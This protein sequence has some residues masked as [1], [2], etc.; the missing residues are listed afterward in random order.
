MCRKGRQKL[1]DFLSFIKANT[2][3]CII[4]AVLLVG[5]AVVGVLLVG[6]FTDQPPVNPEQTETAEGTAPETDAVTGAPVTETETETEAPLPYFDAESDTA[7]YPSKH[8]TDCFATVHSYSEAYRIYAAYPNTDS[9]Q[10][11]DYCRTTAESLITASESPETAREGGTTIVTVDYKLYLAK[12]VYSAVF[13]RKQTETPV[14]KITTS[15]VVLTYN[16]ETNT[17]Y[18]PL[19][20]YDMTLASEP[21][22]QKIRAGYE[23]AFAERGL[24]AD[25]EFLDEVCTPDPSS[26]VNIAVDAHS[27]YFFTVYDKRIIPELLCAEVPFDGMVEYTWAA[28]E[29]EKQASQLP[30]Q[31]PEEQPEYVELPSYD[32][33]AAV[34]A[35]E[36]VGDDYFDDAL[37]IGNSLIVGL[38]RTVPLNARYFASVG[39]NVS[40]VFT[41]ELIPMQSGDTYTISEALGTVEFSKVYLMFGINELGWGSIASFINY[42]GQIID[43]I[44]EVNPEAI[45]Y[46]QSILPINEEK[47]AKSRDYQS[48]I[49]NF[50]VATFN[51]KIIDM[52]VQKNVAFVNVGE[53]LTDETGNLYSD[54]TSDGIHIGG[55]F[56]TRWVEYL[57]THTVQLQI[58]E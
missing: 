13:T 24:S 53:V 5:V 47:W 38:Q 30:P 31:T 3:L 57:K 21:L 35:S 18:A 20:L 1:S 25:S 48:C 4:F 10:F 12:N 8:A 40:Q 7:F 52:C 14:L 16:V 9:E 23:A 2:I 44:R 41:K 45:I 15:V 37:F 28:I 26:F 54:A 39:L 49:N 33:S 43:R 11:N 36:M 51:Q 6:E 56:S 17:V 58:Q 29:A 22:S 32:L 46:V 27:M 42:Y 50:A 55:I 34:P 19:D